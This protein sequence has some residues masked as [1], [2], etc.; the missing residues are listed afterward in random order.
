M[1]KSKEYWNER[2]NPNKTNLMVQY[3]KESISNFFKEGNVLDFGCGI[4]RTFPLYSGKVTG[5]DFS[6]MYKGR[7][8]EAAKHLDYT[9]IIHDIHESD[10]PFKDNEFS[11]G[12]AIKVLLHAPDKEAKRIIQELGRVCEEVLIIALH[13]DKKTASHCFSRDYNKFITDL[14]FEVVSCEHNIEDNIEQDIIIY[15]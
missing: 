4:G 13:T 10:L 7:A 11:Q 3:E 6:T 1:Y 8:I 9:H 15:R 12:L 14:G 2:P 5:V